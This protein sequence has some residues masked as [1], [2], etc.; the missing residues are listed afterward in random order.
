MP[1]TAADRPT[2]HAV[3]PLQHTGALTLAAMAFEFARQGNTEGLGHLCDVGVSPEL[4]DEQGR[5]LLAVATARGDH[6]MVQM[7]LERG[8]TPI[9]PD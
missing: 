4:C 6:A 1:L 9:K 8:A 2:A 5:S 3:S 7:L